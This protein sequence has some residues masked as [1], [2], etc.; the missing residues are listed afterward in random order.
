MYIYRGKFNWGKLAENMPFTIIF[1]SDFDLGEDAF[2]SW[3]YHDH[4][5]VI[6]DGSIDSI[7]P[8]KNK[9]GLFYDSTMWIDITFPTDDS[10]RKALTADVYHSFDNPS[11]RPD[12]STLTLVYHL[13]DDFQLPTRA[14][15]AFPPSRIYYGVFP[16]SN[17]DAKDEL[18]I[19]VVPNVVLATEP[20]CAYWMQTNKM[21]VNL[22]GSIQTVTGKSMTFTDST[23][24]YTIKGDDVGIEKSIVITLTYS[25][26]NFSI[27]LKMATTPTVAILDYLSSEPESPGE[28]AALGAT[29]LR[30]G[31]HA[32]A[33]QNVANF[34]PPPLPMNLSVRNFFSHL[35]TITY[36]N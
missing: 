10:E 27:S 15:I 32:I 7:T 28:V 2:A 8:F 36:Y 22:G 23:G 3:T 6:L 14:L 17:P 18:F 11:T 24:K 5:H 1:P 20:L 12:P 9:I 33:Q 25:S 4:S 13:A 21:N 31:A 26:T 16:P 35:S 34:M 29:V 30:A 19:L